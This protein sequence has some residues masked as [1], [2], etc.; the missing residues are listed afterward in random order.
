[1]TNI[2]E[3]NKL[4]HTIN[5]ICWSKEIVINIQSMYYI[6][7]YKVV[8]AKVYDVIAMY[9][10]RFWNFIFAIFIPYLIML[11]TFLNKF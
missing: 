5:I 3:T 6:L 8:P 2:P 7:L 10:Y 9:R 4:I 11:F 1:M